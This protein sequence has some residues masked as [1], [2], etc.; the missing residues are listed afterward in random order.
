MYTGIKRENASWS[1]HRW[2]QQGIRGSM[3]F[4]DKYL[5]KQNVFAGCGPRGDDNAD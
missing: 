4:K 3:P 2:L 5:S 1:R